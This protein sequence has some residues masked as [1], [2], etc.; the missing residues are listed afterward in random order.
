MN[1]LSKKRTE[2]PMSVFTFGSPFV[3]A[4]TRN[5][6]VAAL[7]S[8]GARVYNVVYQLDIVPRL[9][10][11]KTL[12]EHLIMGKVQKFQNSRQQYS[13]LGKY[14]GLSRH[15]RV[16]LIEDVEDSLA[17]FPR[18]EVDFAYALLNDHSMSP[19]VTALQRELELLKRE[20]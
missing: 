6:S 11:G 20:R 1:M 16:R 12:P 18:N 4:E 10:G 9:L 17:V 15:G 14:I 5:G 2:V 13:A 8:L 7:K 19:T 3:V